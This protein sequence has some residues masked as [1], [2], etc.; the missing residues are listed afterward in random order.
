MNYLDS[1]INI[2]KLAPFI[3]NRGNFLFR[4][5]PNYHPDSS[6]Y[7]PYWENEE[8]KSIEGYWGLDQTEKRTDNE[9]ELGVKQEYDPNSKG[10]W[11][12]MTPQ[13]YWYTNYCFIQ[14]LP[15][16]DEPPITIMPDIRDID[17]YWFYI[18]LIASGFSGFELDDKYSCHYLLNRYEKSLKPSSKITFDLTPKEKKTWKRIK[19]TLTDINGNYKKYRDP[20][21]YLNDTHEKPLGNILYQNNMYNIVDLE[22]RGGGKSYRMMGVLS[23]AFNFFG[24]RTFDQYLNIKK[25]PTLCVGS[26]LST[27]SGEL[28]N[29]FMFS[30]SQLVDNFGHYQLEDN[31]LP[32]FFHKETSGVMSTGNE[33]NPY[34]HQYKIKVGKTWKKEGT[35]TNIIH[36]SYDNNPEAFVGQRATLMLEDEFGINPLAIKCARADNTVMK[37]SGVKM[38]IGIK[39]GTGGNVTKIQGAKEIYYHPDDYGYLRLEDKWEGSA[40]GIGMFI[41]AIYV[42]SSFRDP[43]GNQNLKDAFAQE[44][45]NR[46]KLADGD[47]TSMLDGYIIDHPL[48]PSEM[49]LSPEMN[50]FPVTLL[51]EHKAYIEAKQVVKKISREGYLEYIDNKVRDKVRFIDNTDRYNKNIDSFD[52]KKYDGNLDG[53]ILVLEEPVDNIP[54]PLFNK[55]LYKIGYDPVKDD[56][57]G[58]SLACIIVYKGYTAP[59]WN[60]GIQNNI[61]AIYIGRKDDVEEMHEIA[62][63]LAI[64]YNAKILPETNIPDFVRYCKRKKRINL[65]QTKPFDAISKAINNPSRK[66]DVGMDVS[67]VKIIIQGEQ[68]LKKWL[69]EKRGIDDNGKDILNLHYLYS[70]RVLDELI[71]Y[72]RSLNTDAISTL[73]LIMF[74]IYQEELIP[75][76]ENTKA[77]KVSKINEYYNTIID[78]NN[79]NAE[80]GYEEY[81]TE[82]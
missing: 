15:N 42:D 51:R 9:I 8:V 3:Y 60:D 45:H 22:A 72:N 50:I 41:P 49:F 1:N 73:F 6:Q 21:E 14:H 52:L 26:A 4:E 53:N 63:K 79:N 69:K 75:A 76:K 35:W 67:S 32:G 70:T 56:H 57:G 39:S 10:G 31:F 64:W 61:V 40:F 25:G 82:I 38:G 5:H 20:I 81:F 33:K 34:R 54:N 23:Q 65:L 44:I 18:F 2:I 77:N 30:Q 29:K 12:F 78:K 36:N 68:L 13:H 74:W 66:Y 37:M 28:L 80:K 11:R 71:M 55:S 17:W 19:S 58:P 7:M 43:Q 24:A 16:P 47:S 46:K 62:I 27:K 48:V 59:G